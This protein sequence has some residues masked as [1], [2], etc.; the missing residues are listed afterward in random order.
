MNLAQPS[1]R[2]KRS[3]KWSAA[4][5]ASLWGCRIVG[6][7][8][9]IKSVIGFLHMVVWR[10]SF[11]LLAVV[12][13]GGCAASNYQY[14]EANYEVTVE[15]G[16]VLQGLTFPAELEV[17]ILALD[18]EHI[19]ETDVK[20]ILARSPAP[21]I[22]NIH[23]GVPGVYLAME[24]FSNFLIG[25]GYPEHKIRNPRNGSYSYSPYTSSEK[26][27]GIIAWYYE[28]EG[29]RVNLVG[30][31]AGGMEVVKVLHELGGSFADKI[32]VWNPL[33]DEQ[34]DRFA[35]IDP[36]TGT[37]RPV[38]GVH[39]GYATA[40]GAGGLGFLLPHFWSLIG[41]LRTIPNST[42]YF[43]GFYQTFDVIGGTF[44]GL[45]KSANLYYPSGTA[46]VRNVHLPQLGYWHGTIP[47][48]DH[49]AEN[50]ATRDWINNYIP[51]DH[52]ELPNEEF[53]ADTQNI[54]WAADVWH[55]IKKQWCLELQ[56]LIS[57]KRAM[58]EASGRRGV[59]VHQSREG[60]IGHPVP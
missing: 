23:G 12:F 24:S 26:L 50:R 7:L 40:V 14:H 32:P 48:T 39:V 54:L 5:K 45:V 13:A 37:E 2:V 51:S 43:T 49:L 44:F 29:M 36:I 18:P 28:K 52:L 59:T 55:S 20:E 31:S 19:D 15:K 58:R 57:A 42:E 10:R 27:A 60:P 4:R 25:M 38:V 8:S 1:G 47:V 16:T 17:R 11:I 46:K 34:E 22:I 33:T 35:I 30:H 53:N 6:K 41:K 3:W 21:R 9:E 56:R